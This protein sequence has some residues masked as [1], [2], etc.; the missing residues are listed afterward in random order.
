[1]ADDRRLACVALLALVACGSQ[2][3]GPSDLD[4]PDAAL[5][6]AI[7]ADAADGPLFDQIDRSGCVPGALAGVDP[8]GQ[9]QHHNVF[10]QF[11]SFPTALLWTSTGIG[12]RV[13]NGGR[14]AAG[15]AAGGAVAPPRGLHPQHHGPGQDRL[16]R[17]VPGWP[18]P[19]RPDRS[20]PPDAGRHYNT[21]NGTPR[22]DFFGSAIG[23]DVDSASGLIYLADIE[24][25]LLILRRTP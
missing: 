5:P 4:E 23:I 19:R 9:W 21:W 15:A 3:C 7:P 10:S 16:H 14:T 12:W 22:S 13:E 8:A 6:D 11:S 18:A 2:S 17:L 25:G 20:R 24:R 1:L